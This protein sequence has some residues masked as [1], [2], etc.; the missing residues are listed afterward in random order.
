MRFFYIGLPIALAACGSDYAPS[1]DAAPKTTWFQD[2]API[3]SQ[4]CM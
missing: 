1:P 2:V 3:V 4:H